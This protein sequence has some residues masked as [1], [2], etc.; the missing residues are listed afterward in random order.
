DWLEQDS[1]GMP[2]EPN[3]A[4][5]LDR[6]DSRYPETELEIDANFYAVAGQEIRSRRTAF[7]H[8]C[9]YRIGQ[10]WS[11]LPH[12]LTAHETM[13][14]RMRAPLRPFVPIVPAA[15][16]LTSPKRERGKST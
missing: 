14:R 7:V 10:L 3:W 2:W 12:K 1:T 15:S 5:D 16:V 9:F 13:G 8:S 11:P 6:S 4:P